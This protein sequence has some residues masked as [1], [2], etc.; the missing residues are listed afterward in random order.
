MGGNRGIPDVPFVCKWFQVTR[1]VYCFIVLLQGLPP[2]S[3]LFR[4][5]RIKLLDAQL[6]GTFFRSGTVPIERI[7]AG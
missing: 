5:R 4:E 2:L 1:V 3:F 7:T 6:K